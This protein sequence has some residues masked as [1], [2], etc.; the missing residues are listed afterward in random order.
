MISLKG[1]LNALKLINIKLNVPQ[2]GY[3]KEMYETLFDVEPLVLYDFIVNKSG[4]LLIGCGHYKLNG[5]SNSLYFAGRLRVCNGY[6][7]YI[8][9]DSGHYGPMKSELFGICKILKDLGY[10]DKNVEISYFDK[11]FVYL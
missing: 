1:H 5:K 10:A 4:D 9:N 2:V 7:C 8:D 6:I 3:K 11:S